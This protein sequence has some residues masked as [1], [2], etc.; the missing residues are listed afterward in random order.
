MLGGM[1]D[2][3]RT[4]FEPVSPALAGGLFITEPPGKP[5]LPLLSNLSLLAS[6]PCSLTSAPF[7]LSR[8]QSLHMTFVPWPMTPVLLLTLLPCPPAGGL[9]E[10][11]LMEQLEQC[12]LA[13]L[14]SSRGSLPSPSTEPRESSK[15][16][17]SRLHHHHHQYGCTQ[18]AVLM[19]V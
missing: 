5:P 7:F 3:P 6:D 17:C 10:E 16:G 15:L 8:P 11:E 9:T 2:L 12:D 13:P 18:P 1:W 4:G 14:A 19:I